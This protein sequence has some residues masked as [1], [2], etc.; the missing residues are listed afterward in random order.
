MAAEPHFT[1]VVV[2]ARHLTYLRCCYS[3]SITKLVLMS[4]APKLQFC[5]RHNLFPCCGVK[6]ILIGPQRG[7]IVSSVVPQHKYSHVNNR[8]IRFMPRCD[9]P[10]D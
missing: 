6:L 5:K 1:I 8:F 4:F 2:A 10:L 3:S 7:G 9:K